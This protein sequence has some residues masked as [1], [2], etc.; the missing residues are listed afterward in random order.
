MLLFYST[1]LFSFLRWDRVEW[2][3][4]GQFPFILSFPHLWSHMNTHSAFNWLRTKQCESIG[5]Q[6]YIAMVKILTSLLRHIVHHIADHWGDHWWPTL[7]LSKGLLVSAVVCVFSS[8][9]L[10]FVNHFSVFVYT[11]ASMLA[12]VCLWMSVCV[13]V[14]VPLRRTAWPRPEGL[15][16]IFGYLAVWVVCSVIKLDNRK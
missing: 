10:L 6:A 15:S 16:V 14:C 1:F 12:G 2:L 4:H 11:G 5:R 3:F 8:C 9:S 13:C 7:L